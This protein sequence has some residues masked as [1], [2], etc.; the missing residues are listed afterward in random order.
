MS[1]CRAQQ[2]REPTQRIGTHSTMANWIPSQLSQSTL[3]PFI[4]EGDDVSLDRIEENEYFKKTLYIRPHLM[5]RKKV[6]DEFI[7]SE[8]IKKLFIAGPPG[9]GKTLF[10]SLL[11]RMY[12]YNQ[13]KNVLFIG[14]RDLGCC[15]IFA[16][17][18]R[19][20]PQQL[21][22]FPEYFLL[23]SALETLFTQLTVKYDLVVY[24]GVRQNIEH[25]ERGL[26]FLSGET[27]DG[28]TKVI[29]V[30]SLAFR[31]KD[32]DVLP[33]DQRIHEVD[34]FDSWEGPSVYVD[35]I[36]KMEKKDMLDPLLEKEIRDHA[37][38]C[39]DKSPDHD[40]SREETYIPLTK[41]MV[42][43]YVDLKYY[44]AGGS[45]RFMFDYVVKNLKYLLV[46]LISAIKPEYWEAFLSSTD[47]AVNS[48]MQ[49]FRGNCSIAKVTGVSQFVV[50]IGY[51]KC[52]SKVAEAVDAA[53]NATGNPSLRGWA[54]ELKQLEIIKMVF[55][56]PLGY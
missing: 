11:A 47:D 32:G 15:P 50:M 45:A 31:I 39:S 55:K 14:Y 56:S 24:D 41:E 23:S 5:E 3:P 6:F 20:T 33:H 40:V 29:F 37:S 38:S 43:D 54:F 19:E 42:E 10:V 1:E 2:S 12:A 7:T 28:L 44:F 46:G 30:T 48:L 13:N 35:A 18:G 36:L 51:D 49:R 27:G 34:S 52:G 53:A 8:R 9:S 21:A 16:F 4:S 17:H 22:L 25:S 26:G